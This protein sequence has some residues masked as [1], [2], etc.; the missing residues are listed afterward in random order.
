LR[1]G[2]FLRLFPNSIGPQDAHAKASPHSSFANIRPLYDFVEVFL[3]GFQ[4]PPQN[5]SPQIPTN[6]SRASG[7]FGAEN[8][9]I[10]Q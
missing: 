2:F 1:G 8:A 5:F 7:Y 6:L 3:R 10:G 9:P 4:L